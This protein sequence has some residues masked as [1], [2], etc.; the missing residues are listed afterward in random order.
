MPTAQVHEVEGHEFVLNGSTICPHPSLC[1][2]REG[3]SYADYVRR[4]ARDHQLDPQPSA[5]IDDLER[6]LALYCLYFEHKFVIGNPQMLPQ[7]FWEIHEFVSQWEFS[8]DDLEMQLWDDEHP[9]SVDTAAFTL[10]PYDE[11][12]PGV[13]KR[14]KELEIPRGCMKTSI[15]GKAYVTQRHLRSY[16]IEKNPN[17]RVIITSATTTLTE[18]VVAGLKNLWSL[19]RNIKRLFGADRYNAKG[20]LIRDSIYGKQGR[21]YVQLRWVSR[22]DDSS[23]MST[24]SVRYAGIGTETTGMRADL[25]VFDDGATKKNTKTDIQREKAKETFVEQVKQLDPLGQLVVCNTRKHLDDFGG[26]IKSAA[27]RNR[28]HILHRRIEWTDPAT[29]EQRFY[30][31]VTGEGVAKFDDAWIKEQ[32]DISSERDF[33]SELYNWPMDP[34]K[35][36]FKREDF[37]IIH[38]DNPTVPLEIKAGLGRDLTTEE[39]VEMDRAKVSIVGYNL[40]DPAGKERQSLH[41]DDTALVGLRRDRWGRIWITYLRAGQWNSTEVW[42]QIEDADAYNHPKVTDYELGATE[43]HVRNSLM[44]YLAGRNEERAKIGMPALTIPINF[45]SMPK[46]SKPSRIESLHQWTRNKWFF[47]LS[48]AAE[49][50]EIQKFIRQFTEYLITGHDDYADATSRVVRFLRAPT[51]QIEAQTPERAPGP[52][53]ENGVLKVKLEHFIKPQGE[54]VASVNWG[55]RGGI[56][57]HRESSEMREERA[58]KKPVRIEW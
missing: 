49:P 36:L 42:K 2:V 30:F 1:D 19:N 57:K 4:H 6:N 46:S 16:F 11:R 48:N 18:G 12:Q 3:E 24:F 43:L 32:Y 29:K 41:G 23:G 31:P 51:K 13:Y 45:E 21:D 27:Y 58:P 40:C 25:Y 56:V 47:I 55:L 54:R 26:L 33:W 9:L 34:K 44:H 14:F 5:K 53:M 15:V 10:K 35:A 52:V 38:P 8:D 37:P 22:A 7:P 39:R 20:D 28:F 17:F 50:Q